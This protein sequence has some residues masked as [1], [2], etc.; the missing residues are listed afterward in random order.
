MTIAELLTSQRGWGRT[1]VRK[2]LMRLV[3][4]E[5]KQLGSLTER[6]RRLVAK[7]LAMSSPSGSTEAWVTELDHDEPSHT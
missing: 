4:S 5:T 1:R 2:F 3:I 6:Q 7:E